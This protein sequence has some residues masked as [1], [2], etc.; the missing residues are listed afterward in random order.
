MTLLWP[1]KDAPETI[2]KS[3]GLVGVPITGSLWVANGSC[4]SCTLSRGSIKAT[5]VTMSSIG[6]DCL[7]G[8]PLFWPTGG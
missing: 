7:K 4:S 3:E 2:T 1:C 5:G 6:S 8:L